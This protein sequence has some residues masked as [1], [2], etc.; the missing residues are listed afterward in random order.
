MFASLIINLKRQKYKPL[1][2]SWGRHR[3]IQAPYVEHDIGHVEENVDVRSRQTVTALNVLH[4]A[5]YRE[6]AAPI[7][8][9]LSTV[10]ETCRLSNLRDF[11]SV[12]CSTVC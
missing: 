11:V 7:P 8:L 5:V 1:V 9:T 12:V 10:S 3:S 2:V 6:I 4:M